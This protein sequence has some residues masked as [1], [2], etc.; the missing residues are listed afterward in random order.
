LNLGALQVISTVPRVELSP[1]G[2]SREASSIPEMGEGVVGV[3]TGVV[4]DRRYYAKSE[5]LGAWDV[6]LD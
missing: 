5:S 4:R 6:A 3:P 2:P 1:F